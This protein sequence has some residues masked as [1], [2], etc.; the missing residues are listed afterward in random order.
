MKKVYYFHGGNNEDELNTH[1]R[2]VIGA[3]PGE[4][5]EMAFDCY[6][7]IIG[8]FKYYERNGNEKAQ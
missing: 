6:L 4:L 3:H 1:C 5:I 2:D 8:Q 7:D